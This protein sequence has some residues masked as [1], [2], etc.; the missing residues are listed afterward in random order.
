MKIAR[1][2]HQ[3]PANVVLPVLPRRSASHSAS[4]LHAPST[5]AFAYGAPPGVGRPCLARNEFAKILS[6]NVHADVQYPA[7]RTLDRRFPTTLEAACPSPFEP[8]CSSPYRSFRSRSL[9]SSPLSSPRK[10]RLPTATPSSPSSSASPIS[11]P[12]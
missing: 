1:S 11:S 9:C 10:A 8:A 3:P 4:R 6:V 2:Y 7:A 12:A 5:A